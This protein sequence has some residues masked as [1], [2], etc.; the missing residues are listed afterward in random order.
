MTDLERAL[1]IEQ[2]AGEVERR[3]ARLK[4]G[5]CAADL[6]T[7]MS[8]ALAEIVQALRHIGAHISHNK[9]ES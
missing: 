3:S 9:G 1:E 7:E 8:H 4:Q 5:L 2:L 6:S